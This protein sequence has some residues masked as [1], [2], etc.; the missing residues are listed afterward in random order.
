MGRLSA[1]TV[2]A[3]SPET[4]FAYVT[5]QSRLSEWNDH[6]LSA[7]VVGSGPVA[8]GA[9]LEQHRRRNNREFT[10]TSRC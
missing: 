3:T 9:R 1:E 2:V 7:Q 10:L 8:E 6:V 5:D 4:T